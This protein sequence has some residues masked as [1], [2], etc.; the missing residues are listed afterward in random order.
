[1]SV[2]IRAIILLLPVALT[3]CTYLAGHSPFQNRDK[4]YL[5]AKSIP[6][7]QI[8]TDL[9][10]RDFS[11]YYPVSDRSYAHSVKDVSIVPPG[12]HDS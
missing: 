10:S 12:L 1:M 11:T 6:P 3:G 5:Q 7:M 8:P 4:S 2:V 9:S